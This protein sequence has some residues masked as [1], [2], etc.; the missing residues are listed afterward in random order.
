[1]RI[2]RPTLCLLVLPLV[3][4]TGCSDATSQ[5]A[6]GQSALSNAL[7][8]PPPT[9][10]AAPGGS[11][12]NAQPPHLG[13]PHQGGS[14]ADLFL[15]EASFG[16]LVDVFDVDGNTGLR[17]LVYEDVVVGASVVSDGTTYDL[18]E[19]LAQ[20]DELTILHDR[21]TQ[22]FKSA[23]QNAEAQRVP[24]LD[25]GLPPELGPWST[26]QRDAAISLQ[27]SDLLDVD[28]V[29]GSTVKL[30]T[31]YPPELPYEARVFADTNHGA[32]ADPDG[33][34]LPSFYPTRVVLDLTV[35]LLDGA[36]S[37]PP[38]RVNN[39]GLPASVNDSQP[40]VALRIPTRAA[41]QSGQTEILTNLVG[42]GL[43]FNGNGTN[44]GSVPTLDI[45]RA[46][47]AGGETDVT[48]DPHNGFLPDTEAPR[49]VNEMRM[50]FG[51][52]IQADP[53]VDNGF[54]VGSASFNTVACTSA[55][56]AGDLIQQNGLYGVVYGFGLQSG[57]VVQ[58]LRVRILY[59]NTGRPT[60]GL[61]ALTTAYDPLFDN[62]D[63]FVSYAPTA[64]TPPNDG[65]S[66][67]ASV[68]VRFSEPMDAETLNAFYGFTLA[69][70]PS[71]PAQSGDLIA[72]QVIPSVDLLAFTFQASAR[73]PHV[74]G[75]S[76]TYHV[77]VGDNPLAPVRDAAGNLL[78]SALDDAEL[79]LDPGAAGNG[80]GNL[81]LRFESGDMLGGDGFEEFRGQV[82]VNASEELMKPRLV[83]RFQGNADR[84]QALPGAMIPF[85]SGVQTP[86]V[87]L[88][89]KLH[90]LWRYADLGFGLMDD[91]NLNLDVEGLSWAPAGGQVVADSFPEFSITL[92]H[93][94]KLP[95]E[96]ADPLSQFP[97]YPASGLGTVFSDNFLE[98]GEV[99]HP[100]SSG[101]VVSPADLYTSTTGTVLIPYPLNRGIAV[102]DYQHYTWRDTSIQSVGGSSG[103]GVPLD[104]EI[105]I[106][107]LGPDK[108][109]AA[110]SVPT[111]GL[112]LLSEFRVYPAAQGLGLN[113]LD[114]SLATNS[115]PRPNFRAYSA[116]GIDANGN[117]VL[118]NPDFET[119]ASGG[120]NPGSIPPG[121]PTMPADNTFY[122]GAV[123]F[124]TTKSRAHSIWLDTRSTAPSFNQANL[125]GDLPAGTSIELAFRGADA[126]VGGAP[127]QPFYIGADAAG[128][129]PYGDPLPEPSAGT[130]SFF[131][132]DASW[133]ADISSL[134]G[135]RFVQVR[136]SFLGDPVDSEVA[137]L[138]GLALSW[139]D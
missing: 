74:Q 75:V 23:L 27:F 43:A 59:S 22:A 123:D 85:S 49:V 135:A 81:V 36:S 119:V 47:R 55:V 134:S 3:P 98:P 5:G 6:L 113:A 40:N 65:V 70:A 34:G 90:Q 125:L 71:S 120:F 15:I 109:Y 80:N 54:V 103:A 60:N 7:T 89:S 20:R 14:A 82:S 10:T 127:G 108:N 57:G 48:G 99:V 42:S 35:S 28:S 106:N 66:P 45:L 126:I 104:Q 133:K 132:G 91:S 38:L 50:V 139:T 122:I 56:S 105:L 77:H 128:L 13:D 115:S 64:T 37:N 69:D 33:D 88:G 87:P 114:V 53:L 79:K 46:M 110:G 51:G 94:D 31:G 30:A 95:D 41:P 83:T 136:I 84:S 58:D 76:E 61:A 72:G 2:I 52:G 11:Q 101:Y 32:L 129:D 9:G 16:R 93:G 63:C 17:R 62:S 131:G 117:P 112:P 18:G 1:M 78:A 138:D 26:I 130:P 137:K 86:L 121:A 97:A 8:A 96:L 102:E 73:L 24:I 92:G 67:D 68:S 19:N 29:S 4:L 107:G 116:G 44:D 39:L 21:G 100:R 111:I 25:A 124:V 12:G 118:V